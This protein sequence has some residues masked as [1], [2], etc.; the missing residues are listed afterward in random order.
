MRCPQWRLMVVVSL[1]LV[2][3][4]QLPLQASSLWPA[5]G[6]LERRMKRAMMRL[7]TSTNCRARWILRGVWHPTA[8]I[9]RRQT[10]HGDVVV[11]GVWVGKRGE[12]ASPHPDR[13]TRWSSP[14]PEAIT[15]MVS[16]TARR[17]SIQC[18]TYTGY[19]TLS[20]TTRGPA[21]LFSMQLLH[22][23]SQ[24]PATL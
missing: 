9:C 17:W 24:H 18:D 16:L 7:Q 14:D 21:S 4:C 19:T 11:R 23:T 6:R 22:L 2:L 20:L 3:Q 15:I 8:E 1:I 5:P 13:Q 10:S 12:I